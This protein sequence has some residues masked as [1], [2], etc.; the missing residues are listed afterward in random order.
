MG[1][2]L[3]HRL[4]IFATYIPFPRLEAQGAR[5]PVRVASLLIPHSALRIPY[6]RSSLALASTW[7]L[8]RIIDNGWNS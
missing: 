4:I 3:A 2:D 5:D 8:T 1:D 6:S 7:K